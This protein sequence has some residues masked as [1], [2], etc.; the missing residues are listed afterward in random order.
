VCP[1]VLFITRS[2]VRY[3]DEVRLAEAAEPR[4]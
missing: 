4:P 2:A 1:A 3:M